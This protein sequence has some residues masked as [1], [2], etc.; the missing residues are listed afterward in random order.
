MHSLQI[1]KWGATPALVETNRPQ[2]GPGEVVVATA[3]CGLNFA[4]LLMID[5]KYQETPALPVTL[6]MEIA[7][8]VADTGPGVNW[9]PAGARVAAVPGHG[10]LAGFTKVRAERCVALPTAVDFDTAAAFQIAYGT[11]HLALEAKARLRPGETLVVLGAAGGVGLTA[12]ELGALMGARVI[13]VARGAEKQAIAKAAGAAETLDS[14]AEDLRGAIKALG[15]ADVV[16]DAVGG[17]LFETA[18]RACKPGA[19][20]MVIGFAGGVPQIPANYLL[21]KNITV[22]GLWWGGLF[23]IDPGLVTG[24]LVTL[25]GWLAEG[26]VRPHISARLPLARAAEGLEM[27][28]SR[29]ATGKVIVHPAG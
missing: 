5:G 1:T 21:V 23:A 17:G 6:G 2:P 11:S 13:A 16:F 9:P 28:R 22:H 4:D 10:G 8:R 26:R 25:T 15:G 7:G 19:R 20:Y 18:L 29:T 14:E 12:V 24:S 27:L 3:A